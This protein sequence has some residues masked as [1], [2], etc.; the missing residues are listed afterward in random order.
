MTAVK[1]CPVTKIKGA[2]KTTKCTK[3]LGKHC[4]NWERPYTND[5]P[6]SVPSLGTV[7]NSG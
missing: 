2:I 5:C 3:T 1:Y 7:Q 6:H 4:P